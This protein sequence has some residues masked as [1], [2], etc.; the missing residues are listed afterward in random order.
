VSPADPPA[1]ATSNAPADGTVGIPRAHTFDDELARLDATATATAI[2]AGELS[3]TEA[4]RA[5]IERAGRVDPLIAA[6][7]SE[8]YDR[9]LADAGGRLHASPLAGVPTFIKDMVDVAGLP[10]TWGSRA[11]LGGPPATHTRGIATQFDDMGMVLLGKSALP[12]MGF[13]PSTEPGHAPP[14]RNPWN[15]GHTAGG[16]SG[17]AAAL[18]AA[19]VVPIAH[20]ADGGGSTRIPAASCG[21]VGLKPTRGRLLPHREEQ[22]LP[23]AVTVDGVVTRSVRDTA[24]WYAEAEKRYRSRRLPPMGLVTG[25]PPRRLRIGAVI[26]LPIDVEVDAP[27]RRVFDETITLLERLGHSVTETSAPVDAQFADDFI[28][29]FELLSFLATSTAT[30]S[31]GRHVKPHRFTD[32][33]HGLA[34]GFRRN[35]RRVIGASRRLRRTTSAAAEQFR[36]LDVVLSPVLTTVPPELGYLS[37]ALDHEVLL[38]RVVNWLAFTPLYN[39]AGTPAISLP[40]GS[41]DVTGLPIGMQ[42]GAD[43]GDDALLVQ[44]ALELEAA[45]PWPTLGDVAPQAAVAARP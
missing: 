21:L 8:R 12:E 37:M 38:P 2:A 17:G 26:D 45:R 31:H 25:P 43:T 32:F 18:V 6:I 14:T 19:G 5:A 9:A 23:V 3:A 20:A 39:A 36:N 11:L 44:L 1:P 27:T 4:T 7:I 41:D 35:R 40:L 24:R 13:I 15:L 34:D 30:L 22:L 42:F 16:S 29:Y 10:T 28:A 33:T